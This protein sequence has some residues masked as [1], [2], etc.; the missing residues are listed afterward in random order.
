LKLCYYIY[1]HIVEF[2][3]NKGANS[4]KQ[5]QNENREF[6]TKAMYESHKKFEQE[7]QA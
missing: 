5:Q 1:I 3:T 2:S 4:Y 6:A 7:P